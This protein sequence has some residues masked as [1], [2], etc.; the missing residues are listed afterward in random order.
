V[1]IAFGRDE[2]KLEDFNKAK[3]LV[4]ALEELK[5]VEAKMKG[6]KVARITFLIEPDEPTTAYAGYK[7]GSRSVSVKGRA[8]EVITTNFDTFIESEIKKTEKALE[9]IGSG[10]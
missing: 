8:A 6:K 10:K 1:K 2:M 9:K 4:E 5:A 3:P 7:H